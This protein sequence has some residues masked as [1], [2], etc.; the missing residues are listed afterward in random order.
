MQTDRRAPQA[1]SFIRRSDGVFAWL[2]ACLLTPLDTD[3]SD[4]TDSEFGAAVGGDVPREFED[5]EVYSYFDEMRDDDKRKGIDC[6]PQMVCWA[7][8]WAQG[9][10][11]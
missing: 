4:M 8:F 10:R 9:D 11:A 6:A 2:P 5:S 1:L 3:C 7:E